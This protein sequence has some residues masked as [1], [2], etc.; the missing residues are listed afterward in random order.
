M[1]AEDELRSYYNSAFKVPRVESE[2]GI[3]ASAPIALRNLADS[4]IPG[5]KLLE[6]GCSY[7]FFL[8][9]AR[10]QGWDVTGIELDREAAAVGRDELSLNIHT[11]TLEDAR[12]SPP[13]DV[14]VAFHVIE[15]LT[16]PLRFLRQCNSLLRDNG[17]LMLKTPNVGSWIAKKAG[18]CWVWHSPPAH[19]H[20]FT[21]QAMHLAATKSGFRM[22]RI[23]TQRGDS[24]NNLFERVS[25][26]GR[27]WYRR[28]NQTQNRAQTQAFRRPSVKFVRSLT[29]IV[30]F[31]FGLILDPWL[32]KRNLQPEIVLVARKLDQIG[33]R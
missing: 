20:L 5:K 6:I 11:G 24:N 9:H 4:R 12:L 31:P 26:W 28:K 25:A 19:I 7:G 32:A 29:D 13:Y 27:R 3:A 14:I 18:D 10:K 33:H 1:P 21:P 8:A 15:H 17:I 22:E 16:D 23:W 2:K 30:Y